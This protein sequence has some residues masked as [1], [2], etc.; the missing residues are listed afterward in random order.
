MKPWSP[1]P[2]ARGRFLSPSGRTALK[3]FALTL[4]LVGIGFVLGRLG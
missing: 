3:V 2:R 4:F 1:P